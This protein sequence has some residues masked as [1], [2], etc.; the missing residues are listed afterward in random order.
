MEGYKFDNEEHIHTLDSKPLIGTSSMA[1]VLSK[2]GLTYWAAGLSMGYF[3]WTN[4]G[5]IKSGWVPKDNRLSIAKSYR[6]KVSAMSDDEYLSYIDLAYI[7]HTKKLKDAAKD[8]TD[9]HEVMENYVKACIEKNGGKPIQEKTENP[10]LQFFADWALMNVKKFL[11]SEM[12]CY[13]RALWLGGISDCG[14]E[15]NEGKIVILDFKSSK[16]VYLSQF[17]QCIGYAIQIEENGGFTPGGD[18]ILEQVKIDYV[19]VL[20]FG[21]ETPE[22][23]FY[24]DMKGGAEAIKAM[25]LL[26]RML[27]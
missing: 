26:H 4:K 19:A 3:G 27:S 7:A 9:M 6:E 24:Y 16:D 13:S 23:K 20:P 12:H 1:S 18:K 22:V 8:G 10:K 21:M 15:D 11:W 14:Y 17:W 5:N 25:L 2:P